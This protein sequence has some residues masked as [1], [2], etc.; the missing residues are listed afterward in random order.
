MLNYAAV[1]S[2]KVTVLSGKR[3]IICHQCQ[4]PVT[5]KTKAV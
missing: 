1:L 5:A 3:F 4:K 2:I